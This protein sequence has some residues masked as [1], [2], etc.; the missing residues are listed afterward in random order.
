MRPPSGGREQTWAHPAQTP[1]LLLQGLRAP[2]PP[3]TFCSCKKYPKTRQHPWFW[4][5]LS[6]RSLSNLDGTLP[7]NQKILRASNLSQVSIPTSA[8]TLLKRVD[9][10][11]CFANEK[12]LS[13]RGP[14]GGVRQ[15]PDRLRG[16]RRQ[17]ETF[18]GNVPSKSNCVRLGKS[19]GPAQRGL[20]LFRFTFVRTKVNPGLGRGGPGKNR[21]WGR[22]AP[23]KLKAE[24][25]R[26]RV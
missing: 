17:K 12:Y 2:V 6:N 1:G 23:G 10:S 24:A 25:S 7:L 11:I 13:S 18:S 21:A 8:V 9:E 5:P 16:S 15:S 22:A 3:G 14:T 4:N 20:A 26:L 19:R